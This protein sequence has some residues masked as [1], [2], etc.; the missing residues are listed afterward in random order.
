MIIEIY[1]HS[2]F[3]L[4]MDKDFDFQKLLELYSLCVESGN[5]AEVQIIESL[6]QEVK[7]SYLTIKIIFGLLGASMVD[8]SAEK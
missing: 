7:F 2:T 1:S 5:G 8:G 4:K 3:V 6:P